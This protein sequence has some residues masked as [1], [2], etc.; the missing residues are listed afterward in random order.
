[1]AVA[2]GRGPGGAS[3]WSVT[4][5]STPSSARRAITPWAEV[6]LSTLTT[7]RAPVSRARW[8]ECSPKE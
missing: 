6:P 1:M 5:V 2:T 3:W 7:T 4:T 8:I